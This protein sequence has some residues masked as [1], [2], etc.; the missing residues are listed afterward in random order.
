MSPLTLAE[1]YATFAARG[2][3]CEPR[4][5]TA[6]RTIDK[7][8]IEVPEPDCEQVIE[9]EIADAVNDVMVSVIDG[10]VPSPTGAAMDI[11]R[12]AA[13]KTG[14]TDDY[15]AVWFAGYTPDLAAAV[16]AGHPDAPKQFPMR[17]VTINGQYYSYVFGSSLPGPI[18]RDA[19][20]GALAGVPVSTFTPLNPELIDGAT[21][22]L[23]SLAGLTPQEAVRRLDALDLVSE[24][25]DGEVGSS[26]PQ[27]TVAYTS[28]GAGTSVQPGDT[29]TIYLSNGIAP[30]PPPE[31]NTSNNGGGGN[32]TNDGGGGGGGGG[33][34]NNAPG[35]S[36][37]NPGGGNTNNN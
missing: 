16:W 27:G 6:V 12:P 18:W 1:S 2:L 14:T 29:V 34:G 9:P 26:Q 7:Q 33:G 19:M 5:I 10:R 23:P 13:G 36:D 35:N 15:N 17:A 24:V 31:D 30:P 20:I 4:V 37:G 28:P 3:H 25:A 8:Q 11:G 22:G 32:N 21:L